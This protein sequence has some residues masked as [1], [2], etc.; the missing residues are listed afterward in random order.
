M[1]NA[2]IE[3]KREYIGNVLTDEMFGKTLKH[4]DLK[5]EGTNRKILWLVMKMKWV[6]I[7]Y[8]LT[9]LR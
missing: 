8:V 5:E 6:D 4:L 3:K 1:R 7:C 9:R 2:R